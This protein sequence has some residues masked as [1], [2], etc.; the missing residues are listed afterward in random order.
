MI[1]SCFKEGLNYFQQNQPNG[2]GGKKLK[3]CI[4]IFA[5][6]IAVSFAASAAPDS[7]VTGPYKVSFDIGLTRDSYNVTVPDPVIDETLGGEKR[8]EYSALIL[9]RTGDSRYI[10]ISIRELEKGFPI[11]PTGSML[12]AALKLID[13]NDPHVSGFRSSTRTIDGMDGAVASYTIDGG[14]GDILDLFDAVY[15]PAIAP[16][17]MLVEIISKYPWNEETLRMLKTI[18][19]EKAT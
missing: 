13:E 10:T 16:M 11:K 15:A 8:V 3:H 12:E 2:L 17:N 19:V 4:L 9:N 5:A 1:Q 7:V 14:S 18:H 6:L